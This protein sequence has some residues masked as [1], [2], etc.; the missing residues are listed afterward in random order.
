MVNNLAN[1]NTTNKSYRCIDARSKFY[2]S[3]FTVLCESQDFMSDDTIVTF[4]T[5]L[6]CETLKFSMPKTQF[7]SLTESILVY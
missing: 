2:G 1:K 3:I 4:Q 5:F 7:L 6:G